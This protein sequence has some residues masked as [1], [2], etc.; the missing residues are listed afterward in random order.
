MAAVPARAARG[1]DGDVRRA[2][3]RTGS[4]EMPADELATQLTGG[5]TVQELPDEIR[6]AIGPALRPTDF[7]LRAA[8]EPAV[9]ARPERLALRRRLAQP[10]VL[11]GAPAR[12]AQRRGDLPLPPA[13]PRR[14]LPDLVR[15]RRPRLG[16]RPPR[17]RRHDARRRR[18]RPRRDG[19]AEHGPCGQHPRAEHVRGRRGAARDRRADAARAGRDAPR[20]RLHLLRPRRRHAL[21]A[22]RLPDPA[23][24]VHARAGRP[25]CRPRSRSARSSTR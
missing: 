25:A 10:D 13:L 24:P 8:P 20:H 4:T 17:G 14:R 11:A 1:G 19:R 5:V 12:D 23:D 22:G 2:A 21:R 16:Q 6:S 18:R 3:R 7:V 15:R 9:H